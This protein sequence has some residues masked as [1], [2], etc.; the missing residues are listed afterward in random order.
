M[1]RT[2]I[3]VDGNGRLSIPS[4]LEDLWMSESELI[5][6][7]YITAPKLNAV[8]RA[9]Y[10]E[11]MLS[12]SEVQRREELSKGIWQTLYGF[13][14]VVAICFRLNSNGAAQL[15]DAIIKRLYGA[16]EKTNIVLQ[17]YGG[18]NSFS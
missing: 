15:R 9:I 17:L 14:M 6:M 4:N 12:M 18:T 8:I 11:G 1:K 16:K 7:L 3:T 5:D 10:K 13:P 2:V